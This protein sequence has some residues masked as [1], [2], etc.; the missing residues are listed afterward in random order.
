M[1][2]LPSCNSDWSEN[3][4]TADIKQTPLE[5]NGKNTPK[6]ILKRSLDADWSRYVPRKLKE[7][8]SKKLKETIPT[9]LGAIKEAYYKLK[10]EY[11]KGELEELKRREEREMRENKRREDEH[12]KKNLLLD[13]DRKLQANK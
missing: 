5:E 1:E 2:A 12:T 11:L 9:A 3:N 6:S 7:P 8:M 13:L 10:V 4:I